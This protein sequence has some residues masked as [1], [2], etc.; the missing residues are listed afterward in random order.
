M[1]M[2]YLLWMAING[3]A[4]IYFFAACVTVVRAAW[5]KAGLGPLLLVVLGLLS[6]SG[7][8][9]QS[10]NRL[11]RPASHVWTGATERQY[12]KLKDYYLAAIE[13]NVLYGVAPDSS[14]P[15]WSTTTLNGLKLGINWRPDATYTAIKGQ[16]L[17]YSVDG[18]VDWQ[19]LGTTV[20]R[21]SKHFNGVVPR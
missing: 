12:I 10:A 18:V 13:L 8:S 4:L 21:E 2:L 19:L 3:T 7:N 1:I 14:Q 15:V 5:A 17:Y 6:F 9:S 16:Q 11:P 20:Y